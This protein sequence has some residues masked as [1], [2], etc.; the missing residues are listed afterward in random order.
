MVRICFIALVSI[1]CA[2]VPVGGG[3]AQ[4]QTADEAA[5]RDDG[6]ET[7]NKEPAAKRPEYEL[8]YKYHEG[9]VLRTE[10]VHRATVQTTIQG[11]SQTAETLS[12][13]IKRWVV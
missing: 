10:I 11:T 4:D 7:A 5:P 9:E 3:W 1:G 12:K 13:S 2:L 8:R 6:D